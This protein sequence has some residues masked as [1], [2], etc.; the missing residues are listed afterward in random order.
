MSKIYGKP[1]KYS[2]FNR[3]IPLLAIDLKE[4]RRVIKSSTKFF[5]KC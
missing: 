3:I 4:M 5:T 1:Q 2:F